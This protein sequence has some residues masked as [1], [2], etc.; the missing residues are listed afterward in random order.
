MTDSD[1][2][3]GDDTKRLAND[4]TQR[5]T[6]PGKRTTLGVRR[7]DAGNPVRTTGKPL[8]ASDLN[9][10]RQPLRP[11]QRRPEPQEGAARKPSRPRRN[12]DGQP[13]RE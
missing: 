1:D 7:D 8:R 9:R 13:P 11:S 12:D 3:P 6:R 10:D 5:A 4:P 2:L